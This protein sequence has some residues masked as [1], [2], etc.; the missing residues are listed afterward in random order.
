[1][2]LRLLSS[3]DI[4]RA[5]PMR[6][7]I[8]AVKVAYAQL[9][10]GRVDLPLRSRIDVAEY[11]GTALFM[12]A[13]I[14]SSGDLAVKIVSVFPHN[15]AQGFPTIAAVVIVLDAK[16]GRP[17]AVLEGAALTAIRTGAASGAATDVLARPEAKIAAIFG[18]GAQAR[19][20]L[21]AVCSV[22]AI[23]HVRIFSLDPRAA[24]EMAANLAGRDPIPADVTVATS[25]AEAIAEADV[26]CTATTSETPVFEGAGLKPGTHVNAIGSYT[27]TM[28]EVDAKTI[29]RALVI[30]DSKEA[31]LAEAGDLLVPIGRGEITADIVHAELGQILNGDRL[32][33]TSPEQI[34]YFK[35]VGLAVQ[36][37]VAAGRALDRAK[38]LGLGQ[39]ISL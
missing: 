31:V 12:P 1:M 9:S 5:L 36:D 35:S 18:S 39:T 14:G 29:T 15:V 19:T 25:P 13:Y 3:D 8:E 23:E 26:I 24:Q 22:R 2:E 4:T 6:E 34:T 28:Q 38:A 20:Q 33:R 10:R 7:A 17:V 16:T 21:E 11:Q 32:G 37:A 27:P 30:V